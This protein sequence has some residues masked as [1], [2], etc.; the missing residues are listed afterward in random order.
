M[1]RVDQSVD[2]RRNRR[3]EGERYYISGLAPDPLRTA[4][5]EPSTWALM[6]IGFG[7]LGFATYRRSHPFATAEMSS[8][9]AKTL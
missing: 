9:A 2:R 5:P 7:G 6:L 8:E 1:G 4:I 3:G